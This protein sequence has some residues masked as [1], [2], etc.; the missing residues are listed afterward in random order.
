VIEA[1]RIYRKKVALLIHA[2]EIHSALN[3]VGALELVRRLEAAVPLARHGYAEFR[4]LN[5]QSW[6]NQFDQAPQYPTLQS[7]D[8][9]TFPI[10]R[11][12]SDRVV[13]FIRTNEDI[14]FQHA[15]E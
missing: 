12:L 3:L 2:P 7:I 11:S 10:M 1:N 8:E 4:K 9:G 15:V 14:L 6:F 13:I 5:D